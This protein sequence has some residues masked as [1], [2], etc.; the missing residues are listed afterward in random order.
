MSRCTAVS[1]LTSLLKVFTDNNRL[2]ISQ[3]QFEEYC[4][5]SSLSAFPEYWVHQNGWKVEAN[6][7]VGGTT[8]TAMWAGAQYHVLIEP[9]L[10]SLKHDKPDFVVALNQQITRKAGDNRQRRVKYIVTD[11]VKV[12]HEVPS[13]RPS[14]APVADEPFAGTSTA[15]PLP[16]Y[17][18]L[19]S[20]V[21]P[22]RYFGNLPDAVTWIIGQG[23][24]IGAMFF[25]TGSFSGISTKLVAGYA[26]YDNYRS[27][28]DWLA[29]FTFAVGTVL[30]AISCTFQIFEAINREEYNV[31]YE[32]W[33]VSG[34]QTKLPRYQWWGIQFHNLEW[35]AAVSYTIG[36]YIYICAAQTAFANASS[37]VHVDP[38]VY[39]YLSLYAYL[40]GGVFFLLS[41]TLYVLVLGD[42][43][44][45]FRGILLPFSKKDW[46]SLN[47]WT[48]WINFWAGAGFFVGGLSLQPQIYASLSWQQYQ[49]WS[50]IGYGGGSIG[51]LCSGFL[52]LCQ[53]SERR[54]RR[55]T[56][57]TDAHAGPGREDS[58]AQGGIMGHLKPVGDCGGAG[59]SLRL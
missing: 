4:G 7:Q 38:E 39:K 57:P 33:V 6:A 24:F 28:Y 45:L 2:S 32:Q 27:A 55:P 17:L 43:Y 19:D 36:C 48:N 34:K 56:S 16:R 46:C 51:F 14:P 42:N 35:W 20:I 8:L 3:E 12:R 13:P 1:P 9:K 31:K 47:W 18:Y 25:I 54:C 26:P 40:V 5:E 44:N 50:G 10:W 37:K 22:W 49:I 29:L 21:R 11:L 41:G 58:A 59:V 52:Y 30:F 15:T 53:L 23:F